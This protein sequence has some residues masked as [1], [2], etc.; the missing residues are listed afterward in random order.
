MVDLTTLD[1]SS[2]YLGELELGVSDGPVLLYGGQDHVV[3]E[4]FKYI[5]KCLYIQ[6]FVCI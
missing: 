5:L 6:K 2:S 3:D 4:A 1:Y